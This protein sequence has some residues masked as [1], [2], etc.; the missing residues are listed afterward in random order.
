MDIQGMV[1][2][3]KSIA[4][5]LGLP[6]GDRNRTYNSRRAQELGKWAE[7]QGAGDV[8][9]RVVFEAYFARGLNIAR[10]EVLQELAAQV[11]LNPEA[12]RSVLDDERYAA[13]VD[14]DWRRSRR[15]GI[16]A[17]P[18]FRLESEILVGAQKTDI[19]RKLL[20]DHGVSRIAPHN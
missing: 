7:E 17:V 14:A 11:G 16:K 18:S 19:L 9:H 1:A 20:Q 13:Q 4:G 8:F 15:Y 12:L 3:L 5:E 2:Y 6:F 10:M